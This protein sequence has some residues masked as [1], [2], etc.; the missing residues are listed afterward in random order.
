MNKNI[1]LKNRYQ[2]LTKQINILEKQINELTEVWDII[3][4]SSSS[5]DTDNISLSDSN[6]DSDSNNIGI[7]GSGNY[8]KHLLLV[9]KETLYKE[10]PEG[11]PTTIKILVN[12]YRKLYIENIILCLIYIII[13]ILKKYRINY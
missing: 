8:K 13:K 10:F 11:E 2:E 12:I 7:G 1:F 9:L 3:D 4:N 5:S 6:S